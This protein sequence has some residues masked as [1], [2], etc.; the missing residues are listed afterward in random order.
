MPILIYLVE[1]EREVADTV[2]KYLE[3]EG[4]MA[5]A[6]YRGD[7]ALEAIRKHPPDLA[8]LDIMLPGIDGLNL[9]KEIRKSLFFPVIF[10]TSRK[11][12]IDRVLGLEIGADDY[13][14]KPFSPREL[15][16]KVRSLFRRIEYDRKGQAETKEAQDRIQSRSLVLDLSKRKLFFGK[17]SIELTPTEFSLLELMMRHPSKIFLREDLIEHVWGHDF[18]GSTRTIDVHVG[19]LRQ[20]IKKL[21]GAEGFIRG[22][23]SVGYA[24]ED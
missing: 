1:D 7:D 11:D 13:M 19:N 14:P 4:Y 5:K 24:F 23:R 15:V 3:Q 6:F 9:L 22:V 17:D 18:G 12:E 20:K 8:I 16:A 2:A 10:L 21:S